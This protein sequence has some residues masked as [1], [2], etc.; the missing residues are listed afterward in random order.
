MVFPYIET[1]IAFVL[2]MLVASLVVNVIVRILHHWS[3]ERA[4]GVAALLGQLHRGYCAQRGVRPPHP[5]AARHTFINDILTSPIL[6]GGRYVRETDDD[7]RRAE[8]WGAALH[9]QAGR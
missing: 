9:E 1:A 4:K 2:V 5:T 6:H 8:A 7:V 3:R